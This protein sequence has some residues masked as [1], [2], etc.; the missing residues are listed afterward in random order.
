MDEVLK[1]FKVVE[2]FEFNG[3][4]QEVG[5]ILELNE[6]QAEEFENKIEEVAE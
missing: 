3:T 4:V 1:K 2:E 5:T 6:A